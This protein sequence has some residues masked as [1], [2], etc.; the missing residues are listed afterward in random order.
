MRIIQ[1]IINLYIYNWHR[2]ISICIV[3]LINNGISINRYGRTTIQY[4]YLLS[5]RDIGMASTGVALPPETWIHILSYCEQSWMDYEERRRPPH[6]DGFQMVVFR[7]QAAAA[8][9]CRAWAGPI[10][11]LPMRIHLRVSKLDSDARMALMQLAALSSNRNMTPV[12]YFSRAVRVTA[13]VASVRAGKNLART[14][15]AQYLKK[16]AIFS[17]GEQSS[18][19]GVSISGELQDIVRKTNLAQK[20]VVHHMSWPPVADRLVSVPYCF[21][22]LGKEASWLMVLKRIK[23]YGS[24]V[25]SKVCKSLPR[26]ITVVNLAELMNCCLKA[27]HQTVRCTAM[28]PLGIPYWDVSPYCVE[29]VT[30]YIRPPIESRFGGVLCLL[31][32]C[33]GSIIVTAGSSAVTKTR[34]TNECVFHCVPDTAVPSGYVRFED[35]ETIRLCHIDI[36][37]YSVFK[38]AFPNVKKISLGAR[39]GNQVE[40]EEFIH[41][42]K[43]VNLI[44]ATH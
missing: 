33:K 17:G 3:V 24:N 15:I 41:A 37:N 39:V 27:I 29:N 44:F 8:C 16:M 14:Q 25:W 42:D 30:Y 6:D 12:P 26:S 20:I 31:P 35:I 5:Q 34:F 4:W 36:S 9:V 23:L 43:D 32:K 2:N 7:D 10:S 40:L 13:S 22:D 28:E 38:R 18:A 11:G 1:K 19:M 21:L